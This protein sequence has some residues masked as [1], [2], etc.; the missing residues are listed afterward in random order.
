MAGTLG[1]GDF[2]TLEW[3]QP[4][5]VHT[6]LTLNFKNKIM[7]HLAFKCNYVVCNF[8]WTTGS[9]QIDGL[10]YHSSDLVKP[11]SC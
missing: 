1:Q 5:G 4:R 2:N 9:E 10:L 3:L 11:D 6:P 8:L 7:E